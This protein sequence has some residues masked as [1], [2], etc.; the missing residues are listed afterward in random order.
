[1]PEEDV[2]HVDNPDRSVE[3]QPITQSSQTH[4][5]DGLNLAERVT[6][7]TDVAV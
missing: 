6:A 7:K 5:F 1:M 4:S 2:D 3:V